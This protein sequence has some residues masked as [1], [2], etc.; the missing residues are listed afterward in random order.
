M[1]KIWTFVKTLTLRLLGLLSPVFALLGRIFLFIARLT[2][3]NRVLNWADLWLI[4]KPYW[5]SESRN[6]AIG[7]LTATLLCMVLNAKAAYY[8]G[9]QLK[10]LNDVVNDHGSDQAFFTDIAWLAGIAAIWTLVGGGYGYGPLLERISRHTGASVESIVTAEGT[11]MASTFRP[12]PF[13]SRM[14]DCQ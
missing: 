10:I 8:F 7:L 3:L 1:E 9:L 14:R 12:A 6:K 13:T 11:S 5:V 4:A 2:R